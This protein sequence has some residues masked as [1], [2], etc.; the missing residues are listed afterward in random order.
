MPLISVYLTLLIWLHI[1]HLKSVIRVFAAVFAL[2]TEATVVDQGIWVSNS[3]GVN[4]SGI[5][6]GNDERRFLGSGSDYYS[7]RVDGGVVNDYETCRCKKEGL[8]R[9]EDGGWRMLHWGSLPSPFLEQT[10]SVALWMLE[11]TKSSKYL[12]EEVLHAKA[13][14]WLPM[15]TTL[16]QCLDVVCNANRTR[17]TSFGICCA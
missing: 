10:R 8:F 7:T 12:C 4:A 15:L 16:S 9:M 11:W 13:F 1:I 17:L 3:V 6:V 2:V 5:G 14:E